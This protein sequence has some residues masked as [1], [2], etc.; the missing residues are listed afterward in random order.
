VKFEVK[1]ALQQAATMGEI[2]LLLRVKV[3]VPQAHGDNI[4]LAKGNKMLFGHRL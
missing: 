2:L 4:W 3:A 1:D